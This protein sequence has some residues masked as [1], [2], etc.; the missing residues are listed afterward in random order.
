MVASSCNRDAIIN[1]LNKTIEIFTSHNEISFNEVISNGLAPVADAAKLDRVSV[2]RLLDK[3]SR[4]MGQIYVWA[5]GKTDDLDKELIE[6]PNIPPTRRWLE[7]LIKGECINENVKDMDEESKVFCGS[8]NLKA[9]LLVPVFTRGEFWGIIA[10]EDHTNYRYFDED[11]LDLL[12]S[13]ARLCA[14]SFICTNKEMEKAVTEAEELTHAITEASPIPYILFNEDFRPIDCNEAAI[15]IFGCSGKQQLLDNYWEKLVPEKQPDG[16]P[17]LKKAVLNWEDAHLDKQVRYKWIHKSFSGELIPVENTM[18]YIKHKGAKLA[19]SFKYDLRETNKMLENIHEHSELLKIRLE[20]QELLSDISRGFISSGDSEIYIREAIA[21]LGHY[22]NVSH[23]LIFNIDY[24]KHK[25]RPAYHWI[26]EYSR[27]HVVKIDLIGIIKSSFPETLPDCGTLPV[28]FCN[29]VRSSKTAEFHQLLKADVYAFIYAPLYV[30][31]RLWGALSIEQCHKSRNWTGDE[32]NFVALTAGTIAGV[33]MRD[34][35]NTML[36]DALDKATIA[37][38]AKGEFLSNTSH[39]IRTPLN[40]IIG[41]TKIA[42]N[43]PDIERKNY[44]LNKIDNASTHLLGVINDVL[45]ISKIEANKL[46]LSS[47]EFNFEKMLQKVITLIT[48]PVNEKHQKLS[49]HIDDKIPEFLIGDD[50]RLAQIITNLLGNAVKFTPENGFINMNAVFLKEEDDLCTIQ[51]SV[52]DTGIGLSKVQQ[53][54]LFQSFQQAEASTVRKYGGTG[55]GLA[56]SKSI[57][58]MMGGKIWVESEEDKGS[59]FSFTIQAMR[60]K[61]NLIIN[62]SSGSNFQKEEEP[63]IEIDSFEGHNILLAED[64][65]INREIVITLLEPMKLGID[66]AQ[67]GIESVEMYRKNPEKY[68]LIFMDVQMPE[69]DGYDATRQ[70]RIFEEEQKKNGNLPKRIPIIAMTANVFKED[71]EKCINSGMDDHLG[72]PL[73]FDMVMEKLRTYLLNRSSIK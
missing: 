73:D 54:R 61:G 24:Q 35:Y 64:I 55:L 30:D 28:V 25:V 31:G 56:I 34:I 16:E 72:K 53:S 47:V 5:S 15:Q 36:K 48:F 65:E 8:F 38:R 41:M 22:Y 7:K 44:A 26:S 58:E 46:E 62:E 49:L 27:L 60:G 52:S 43:A 67:N 2:Y 17:S 68:D 1:A 3:R 32:K 69:M 29:D 4:K 37:S 19:I 20:Q 45:D 42:K 40:T 51:I 39:E 63:E 6:L 9:V 59:T 21:K 14:N 50:Q 70:I 11:C 57:I 12:I 10:L 23:V 33:I 18:S 66:C 71:I 13:A